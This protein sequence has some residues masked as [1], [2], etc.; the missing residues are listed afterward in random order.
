MNVSRLEA[1][2]P[3]GLEGARYAHAP[4]L[5]EASQD[6]L[7]NL[8]LLDSVSD[9]HGL[10]LPNFHRRSR[11]SLASSKPEARSRA[12]AVRLDLGPASI[13]EQLPHP[14][15]REMLMPTALPS[16]PQKLKPVSLGLVR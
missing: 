8:R 14:L 3:I 12:F 9:R 16:H 11:L 1:Y 13:T 2:P 15:L 7:L 5:R 4:L 6:V 10:Q